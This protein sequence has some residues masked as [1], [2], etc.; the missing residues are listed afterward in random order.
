LGHEATK[1]IKEE[2]QAEAARGARTTSKAPARTAADSA[3]DSPIFYPSKPDEQARLSCRATKPATCEAV[4]RE[5]D[6]P[7]GRLLARQVI[8]RGW[9][10]HF[11]TGCGAHLRR[12]RQP[13]N[14]GAGRYAAVS[15]RDAF[16]GAP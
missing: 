9:C 15:G 5:L 3:E 12:A 14:L 4:L 13:A 8:I 6:S 10:A 1:E 2:A 11:G 16:F 7:A